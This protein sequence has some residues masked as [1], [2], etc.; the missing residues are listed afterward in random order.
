MNLSVG[1]DMHPKRAE[2]DDTQP[3]HPTPLD[4]ATHYHHY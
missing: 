4:H 1:W 2:I 3:P